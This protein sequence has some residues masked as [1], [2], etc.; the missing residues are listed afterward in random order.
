V[1][2]FID[3]GAVELQPDEFGPRSRESLVIAFVKPMV[4]SWGSVVEAPVSPVA[5]QEVTELFQH[6]DTT[7]RR[8]KDFVFGE[9]HRAQRPVPASEWQSNEAVRLESQAEGHHIYSGH[10]PRQKGPYIGSAFLLTLHEPRWFFI[11]V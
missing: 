4:G 8:A 11:A 2:D 1:L 9:S 7:V 5:R 6:V 10:Q 3:I